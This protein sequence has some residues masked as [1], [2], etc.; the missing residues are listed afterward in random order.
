MR[1]LLK[2]SCEAALGLALAAGLGIADPAHAVQA[3]GSLLVIPDNWGFVVQDEEI[4][5]DIKAR[6]SSMDTPSV[7]FG[8]P[9]ADVAAT[10]TGPIVVTLACADPTCSAQVPGKIAFVS[11]GASGCV[12]KHPSVSSCS[13]GAGTTVDIA[14]A[15]P[16]A[17]PPGGTV[18]VATIRVRIVDAGFAQLGINAS[19]VPAS[20]IACSSSGANVCAT[21]MATGCTKL[22]STSPINVGVCSPSKIRFLGNAATPDSFEFHANVSPAG[23]IDPPSQSFSVTLSNVLFNPIFSFTLPPG[24]FT[25]QGT[26]Y[27]Y[28]NDAAATT[29]GIRF[30]RIALRSGQV[31]VYKVD[32]HAYDASLEAEATIPGMTTEITIGAEAFA[33]SAV[34]EPKTFGWQLAPTP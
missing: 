28:R 19:T 33:L 1:H 29:G 32:I 16:I 17:L 30:V 34:W 20:L 11:V 31:N 14:F 8:D 21:C 15:S 6:N 13:A 25:Q 22:V 3:S 4:D 12:S 24:S 5:I 10:L 7:S 2:R 23:V 26:T 18:D 9:L 27:T